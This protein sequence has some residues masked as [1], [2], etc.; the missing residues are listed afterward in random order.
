MKLNNRGFTLIEVLAVVA[1]LGIIVAIVIPSV[2]GYF[3]TSK[4]KSEVIFMREMERIIENY[5]AL[6]GRN[7]NFDTINGKKVKKCNSLEEDESCIEVNVYKSNENITFN[8]LVEDGLVKAT[9]I[10]N[11]KNNKQCDIDTEII[12]YK[13]DDYVYCFETKFDCVDDEDGSKRNVLNTCSFNWN[14]LS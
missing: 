2:F 5:I 10:I 12:V 11:P 4:D 13:D 1:I 9:D 6:E 7:I 8:N 3:D 14:D